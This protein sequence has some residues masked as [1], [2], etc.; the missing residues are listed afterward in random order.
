MDQEPLEL[1]MH[2]NVI[3]GYSRANISLTEILSNSW[4]HKSFI[5]L[6]FWPYINLQ[7]QY[8]FFLKIPFEK[9]SNWH[10]A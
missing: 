9:L 10:L 3:G 4:L 8:L 6:A 5:S 1:V 7:I 2:S